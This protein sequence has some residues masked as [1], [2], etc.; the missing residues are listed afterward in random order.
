VYVGVGQ[1][2]CFGKQHRQNKMAKGERKRNRTI[3]KISVRVDGLQG[4]KSGKFVTVDP[5]FSCYFIKMK[6]REK[7]QIEK[8][9]WRGNSNNSNIITQHGFLTVTLV[10]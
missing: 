8:K 3:M 5:S 9:N 7:A 6:E 10:Y 4:F 2:T 1:T